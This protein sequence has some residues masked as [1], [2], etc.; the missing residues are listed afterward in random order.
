MNRIILIDEGLIKHRSI[1]LYKMSGITEISKVL[2]LSKS[3]DSI[4]Q[5]VLYF[6]DFNMWDRLEKAYPTYFN[7]L[8]T[9]RRIPPTYTFLRMIIGYLKQLKFDYKADNIVLACDYGRSW[10]KKIDTQYKAQRKE[11]R[12]AV[13]CEEWWKQKYT[14]FNELVEKIDKGLTWNVIKI[15]EIEADD[16]A[17]YVSR[18]NSDKEIIN[19]S[20]DEDWEMLAHIPNVKIWSPVSKKFKVIKDPM[21]ILL[22]KINGDI[23]DNLLTK[24]QNEFEFERRKKIVNL[25]ELPAW[26]DDTIKESIDKKMPKN[27]DLKYI[28]FQS[29]RKELEKLYEVT[30][31]SN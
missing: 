31:E 28:P 8:K 20:S 21:K 25:L 1:F 4:A 24:P 30:N 9:I 11:N 13:M 15:W 27:L 6:M 5:E 17:S 12:E 2:D 18:H 22:K 29:V 26:V 3:D 7:Q 14:M 23:S 10:R 16:I 19:I